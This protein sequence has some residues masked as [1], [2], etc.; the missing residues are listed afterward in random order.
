VPGHGIIGL[1]VALASG[2]AMALGDARWSG[3]FGLLFF[4]V[5]GVVLIRRAGA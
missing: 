1:L 3:L 4:G 2:L 5:G